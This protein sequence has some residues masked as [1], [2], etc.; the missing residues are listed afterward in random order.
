MWDVISH[1]EKYM[2]SVVCDEQAGQAHV[3]CI[4]NYTAICCH[5]AERFIARN[6]SLSLSLSLSLRVS[7]SA[8]A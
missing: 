7:L 8:W 4:Y 6:L 5:D 2:Y 1:S 3:A